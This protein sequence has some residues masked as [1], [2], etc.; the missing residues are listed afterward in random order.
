MW[1]WDMFFINLTAQVLTDSFSALIKWMQSMAKTTT[2]ILWISAKMLTKLCS[3]EICIV[4]VLAAEST[5]P[6]E[7]FFCLHLNLWRIS[8]FV[9]S[10]FLWFFGVFTYTTAQIWNYMFTVS[11]CLLAVNY[12]KIINLL[13]I[14]IF[15]SV[16]AGYKPR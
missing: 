15:N 5:C 7:H 13:I 2:H 8:L 11:F 10:C 3:F 9:L 1:K 4:C 6:C 16:T 14:Y 12:K